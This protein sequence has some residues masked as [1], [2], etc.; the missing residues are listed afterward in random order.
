[1]ASPWSGVSTNRLSGMSIRGLHWLGSTY[2]R[3]WSRWIVCRMPPGLPRRMWRMDSPVGRVMDR[4]AG[5]M[6]GCMSMGRFP[7]ICTLAGLAIGVRKAP[8]NVATL[9][10]HQGGCKMLTAHQL[11]VAV[12]GVSG[13]V[14]LVALPSR[15]A[16]FLGA[17]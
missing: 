13:V 6:V 15:A 9:Q 11:V 5:R 16:K 10:R 12:G 4:S 2:L 8:K 17:T 1:M 7:C 14:V 3:L